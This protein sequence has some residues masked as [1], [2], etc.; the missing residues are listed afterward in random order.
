MIEDCRRTPFDGTGK[1]EP[2]RHGL[3]G[4]LSRRIDRE[5]RLV[6]RVKDGALEIAHY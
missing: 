3:T 6:S 4:W 5:P 2:L 1:P